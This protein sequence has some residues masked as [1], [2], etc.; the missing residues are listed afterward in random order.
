MK[1]ALYSL[2]TEIARLAGK[3]ERFATPIDGLSVFRRDQPT[4]L[5]SAIYEPSICVIAQGAKRLIVG[6]QTLVYDDKHYLLTS[7]HMP[8]V[9]QVV[10]ATQ[11]QPY[12]G[13]RLRLDLKE[14]TRMMVDSNLP[15][16][17]MK[18]SNRGIST[19]EIT[20]ELLS[21]FARLVNLLF[22]QKAIPILAPTIQREIIYRL[23]TGDQGQQLRQ[24]ASV[25]GQGQQVAHAIEDI[26]NNFAEPLSVE[27]LATRSGMST[28]TFRHHFQAI[29]SHSPLQFQKHLRLQEARRLMLVDHLDAA[30]AAFKV[31]Y[32]SPS[33]FSREYSRMFG[34]PPV[35]DISKLR[36]VTLAD[37]ATTA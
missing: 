6:E 4:E 23:L 13:L 9:V 11:R 15:A 34:S 17:R 14:V 2:R 24:I 35:R 21:A 27:N 36:K 5:L 16:P 29:T 8:T 28:S 30:D 32:E 37:S 1:S 31:G 3:N 19:G 20:E 26:K 22:D 7:V 18:T 12:L 33:Q 25:G 10:K